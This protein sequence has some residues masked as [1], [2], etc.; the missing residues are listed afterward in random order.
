MYDSKT[1]HRNVIR[2]FC[3]HG[4]L[5]NISF[6]QGWGQGEIHIMDIKQLI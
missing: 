4:N 5:S 1:T 6:G 3:I 2:N